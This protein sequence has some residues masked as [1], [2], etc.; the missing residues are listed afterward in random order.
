MQGQLWFLSDRQE[1]ASIIDKL[2]ESFGGHLLVMPTAM[3]LPGMAL[4]PTTESPTL[5]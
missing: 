4:Q 5:R 1:L 2:A 3:A